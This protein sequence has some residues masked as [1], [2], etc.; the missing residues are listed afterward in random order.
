VNATG[1]TTFDGSKDLNVTAGVEHSKQDSNSKT[2]SQS[3]SYTY[4]GGGSASVGKQTSKAHDESL[5]HVNSEVDLNR[6]SGSINKLNI[7]GG[8]VSIA[9][10]GDLKVNEIYVESLQDTASG[11]SSSKGGS[12][13][14]GYGSSG[15]SNVTAGYNQ[16]KGKSD[17]AWVNSQS[18]LLIGNAQNDADLDAMGVKNVTNIGGVIANASC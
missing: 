11:T 8:E 13:G 4:G 16:G 1:T 15:L 12:I 6:V 3:V 9:D 7:Q 17:S 2:N 18:S 14:A 5:T 10:R